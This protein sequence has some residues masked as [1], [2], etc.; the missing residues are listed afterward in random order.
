MYI[1][2]ID[3]SGRPIK[4]DTQ[5]EYFALSCPI[6]LSTWLH[7]TLEPWFTMLAA[8]AYMIVRRLSRSRELSS[9]P[10]KM[11]VGVEL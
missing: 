7:A 9:R 5:E 11:C 2:H 3:A 1:A 8:V 6:A 10:R 4:E